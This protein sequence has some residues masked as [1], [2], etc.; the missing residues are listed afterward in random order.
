MDGWMDGWMESLVEGSHQG[1]LD[2]INLLIDF[3]T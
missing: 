3:D 1:R 2:L